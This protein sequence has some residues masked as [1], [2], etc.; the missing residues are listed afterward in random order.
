MIKRIPFLG[1]NGVGKQ[2]IALTVG[3]RKVNAFLVSTTVKVVGYGVGIRRPSCIER[4]IVINRPTVLCRIHIR[5]I[6]LYSCGSCSVFVVA[7]KRI[8]CSIRIM[9]R[10]R[11]YFRA[12][13][14]F[15]RSCL[16]IASVGIKRYRI[17]VRFPIHG[18]S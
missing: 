11:R 4:I 1:R 12:K 17:G 7:V 15:Y 8:T 5:I 18:K 9:I 3:C 10:D 2:R 13:G 6:I 16:I 14:N